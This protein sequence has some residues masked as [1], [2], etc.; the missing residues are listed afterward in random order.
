ME[1]NDIFARHRLDIGVNTSFKVKLTFKD[2]SSVYTQSLPF[3]INLQLERR[4]HSKI[5]ANAPLWHNNNTAFSELRQP[6]FR[7]T[8]TNWQIASTCRPAKSKLANHR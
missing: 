1:Y 6:N 5:C 3:P 8:K 2:E 7:S 4:P